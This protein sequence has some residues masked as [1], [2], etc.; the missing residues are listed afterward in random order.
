[1]ENER[2]TAQDY[3]DFAKELAGQGGLLKENEPRTHECILNV[4]VNSKNEEDINYV[5]DVVNKYA[6]LAKFEDYD[7]ATSNNLSFRE[8]NLTEIPKTKSAV[9]H[10]LSVKTVRDK[11]KATQVE[12]AKEAKKPIQAERTKE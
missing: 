3:I 12:K 6:I 10:I 9:L 7:E 2:I 8:L 5:L 4:L 11:K 1:M